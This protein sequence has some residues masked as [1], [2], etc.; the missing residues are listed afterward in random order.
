[1]VSLRRPL[2]EAEIERVYDLLGLVDREQN[3]A[4]QPP[5]R[6]LRSGPKRQAGYGTWISNGSEPLKIGK[7]K[8]AQLEGFDR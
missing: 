4:I 3:G 5:R 7:V 8:H 1:M 2:S 6:Q